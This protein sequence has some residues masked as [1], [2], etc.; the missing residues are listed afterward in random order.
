MCVVKMTAHYFDW[1]RKRVSH[2]H[3]RTAV[4]AIKFLCPQCILIY[5]VITI[6]ITVTGAM[7]TVVTSEPCIWA[8][9]I[10]F[11]K[12]N[13]QQ[14]RWWS[15]AE[16]T[17]ND[18]NVISFRQLKRREMK[19]KNA[20]RSIHGCLLSRTEN[21]TDTLLRNHIKYNNMMCIKYALAAKFCMWQE[22]RVKKAKMKWAVHSQ[23]QQ[24]RQVV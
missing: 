9:K 4:Q 6:M 2:K 16:R 14:L 24:V 1:K 20:L 22:K 23:R 10:I 18:Y 13:V 3:P 17:E 12:K 11:I 21:K 7:I 5:V 19:Y 8:G 15:T